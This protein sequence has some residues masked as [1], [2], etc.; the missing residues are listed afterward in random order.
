MQG[1]LPPAPD[2]RAVRRSRI[3]VLERLIGF[4]MQLVESLKQR[5]AGKSAVA[6]ILELARLARWITLAVFLR[7]RIDCGDLDAPRQP[8]TART[9]A[10]GAAEGDADPRPER[11]AL[12]AADRPQRAPRA[13]ALAGYLDR[14]FGE[15]VGLICKG[16]GI[17][18]DWAAWAGEPWA[19]EEIRTRPP[20]S[21]YAN[22]A[23]DPP[24]D[25]A[26]E[27]PPPPP[28]AVRPAAPPGLPAP[29]L[30]RQ[31]RRAQARRARKRS[32]QRRASGAAA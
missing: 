6:R 16:L 18:P 1:P 32:A 31:A 3:A 17:K 24:G 12:E 9:R 22:H 4:G 2:V 7:A 27:L 10:V 11:E 20:K 19:Q 14:P 25:A 26:Q 30:N 8:K 28:E 23:G 15:V 29:P 21:P 13:Y 5:F